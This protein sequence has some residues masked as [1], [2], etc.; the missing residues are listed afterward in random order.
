MANSGVDLSMGRRFL[1]RTQLYKQAGG[2]SGGANRP[3]VFEPEDFR[4]GQSFTLNAR[5]FHVVDADGKTRRWFL[6][7]RGERLGPAL[8][9]PSDGLAAA[10]AAVESTCGGGQ[11]GDAAGG[12][13]HRVDAV[14]RLGDPIEAAARA[15][16]RRGGGGKGPPLARDKT[17]LRFFGAFQVEGRQKRGFRMRLLRARL[18]RI[19]GEREK[20]RGKGNAAAA[21]P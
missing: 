21:R 6:E 17:V 13:Y 5:T 12:R 16:R 2:G 18:W 20:N 11:G 4:P 19:L 15:A 14:A 3:V 10:R 1:R 7:R 8:P 9:F